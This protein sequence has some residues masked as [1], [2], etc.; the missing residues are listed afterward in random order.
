MNHLAEAVVVAYMFLE[1]SGEDVLDEDAAVRVLEN[2]AAIIRECSLAE[3]KALEDA[4]QVELA[5]ARVS[6]SSPDVLDFLENFSRN[7]FEDE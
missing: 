5:A 1:L 3:R 4:V 2:M 7:L 6:Q